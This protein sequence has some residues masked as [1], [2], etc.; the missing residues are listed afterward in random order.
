MDIN[1][2]KY[3]L[4]QYEAPKEITDEHIKKWVQNIENLPE[5]LEVLTKGLTLSELNYPYRPEGWN[6]KKVVHHLAD[7]HMNSFVRFKLTVTEDNPTIKPYHEALWANTPD[8]NTDDI[9]PSMSI[10]KG[11]HSRWTMFLKN[12]ESSDLN[13]TYFHPEDQ[14]QYTLKWMI[15]LYSWHCKHHLAHIEQALKHK[16]SFS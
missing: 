5:K 14:K 3:P 2:L 1:K 6:I 9:N 10:L 8:A 11:L 16:G 13:R 12:L 4:G 15:G 7:S